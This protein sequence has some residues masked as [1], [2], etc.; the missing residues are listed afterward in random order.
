MAV[1]S[2][3]VR[4]SIFAL[5]PHP[6]Y[7][8]S[9]LRAHPLGAPHAPR[10]EALC[11]EGREVLVEEISHL[12]A[13]SDAQARVGA[14][15]DALNEFAGRVSKEALIITRDDRSNALYTHLFGQKNL[16]EFRKPVLSGQLEAMKPWVE[17]LQQSPHPTLS[18]LAPEA[19]ALVNAGVAATEARRLAKQHNRYFR[20]VGNRRQWVDR[21]NAARKEIHG[22]LAKLPHEQP[23]L[24]SDFADHFFLSASPRDEETESEVPETPEAIR[25]EIEGIQQALAAAQ[26][27]LAQAEAA[28][29]E[30]EQAAAE[31]AAD[32]AAL[33]E[34]DRAAQEL[35]RQREALRARLSTPA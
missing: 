13:L 23:G 4:S 7:S 15:D 8:A 11:A 3:N 31:R 24:P 2:V 17:A 28:E 14:A 19:E 30:A 10:F 35:E 25:A 5:F 27:R 33:A 12:E 32:A 29:L 9:R 16:G 21:L 26:V 34:L 20:D 6:M 1:S 22:M 18:A